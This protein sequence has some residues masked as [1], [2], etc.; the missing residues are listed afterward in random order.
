[1]VQLNKYKVCVSQALNNKLL[2]NELKECVSQ[3]FEEGNQ[4]ICSNLFLFF[5]L[6]PPSL[7]RSPLS[8]HLLELQ[9]M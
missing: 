1:M 4:S 2:Y 9:S 6:S 3:R 7:R 8:S 5:T